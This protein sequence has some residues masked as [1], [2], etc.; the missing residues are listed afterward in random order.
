MRDKRAPHNLLEA[1]RALIK[2]Q[3]LIRNDISAQYER[4]KGFSLLHI[5]SVHSSNPYKFDKSQKCKNAPPPKGTQS[6][7]NTRPHIVRVLI[8]CGW[9]HNQYV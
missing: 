3:I 9:N 2:H 6:L 7:Q 4:F 1:P 5:S 8:F